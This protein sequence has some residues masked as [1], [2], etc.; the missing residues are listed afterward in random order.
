[1]IKRLVQKL[2][3]EQEIQQSTHIRYPLEG[4]AIM[5]CW[6][7]DGTPV[8]EIISGKMKVE[9]IYYPDKDENGKQRYEKIVYGPDKKQQK[10]VPKFIKKRKLINIETGEEQLSLSKD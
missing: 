4:E 6:E 2:S 7:L 8:I 9:Y 10:K 3:G 1:M 5:W